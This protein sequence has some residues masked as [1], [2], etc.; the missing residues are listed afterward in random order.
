MAADTIRGIL[1]E[2]PSAEKAFRRWF[3][4]RYPEYD[5]MASD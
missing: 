5:F 4:T 2:Y 3:G 1:K